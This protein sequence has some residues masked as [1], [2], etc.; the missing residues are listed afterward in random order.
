MMT[1]TEVFAYLREMLE[2]E[3][4]SKDVYHPYNNLSPCR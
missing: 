2:Q 3:S 1:S 4:H